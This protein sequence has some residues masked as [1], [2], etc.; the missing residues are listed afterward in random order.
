MKRYAYVLLIMCWLMMSIPS[1]SEVAASPMPPGSFTTKPIASAGEL[2]DVT[3][4]SP[5][6]AQRYAKHFGAPSAEIVEYFRDHL[7]TGVL[8]QPGTYTIYYMSRNESVATRRAYLPAGERILVSSDGTP[9]ILLKCGNPL[10]K[11]LPKIP[12]R[13]VRVVPIVEVLPPPPAEAT[14][15][16][17]V[18]AFAEP[19]PVNPAMEMALAPLA[20]PAVP[21]MQSPVVTEVLGF[22]EVV[23]YVLPALLGAVVVRSSHDVPI[24]E[25]TSLLA[26]GVGAS[27]LLLR[28][29]QRARSRRLGN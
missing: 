21:L 11:Q 9:V 18:V 16:P 23:T 19:I 7:E 6:T 29:R 15:A 12:E 26:L 2:V 4:N 20:Q 24:P 25:P 14:P 5:V 10:L 27:G 28:F 3:M 17:V 22:T 13:V 8:R 1:G